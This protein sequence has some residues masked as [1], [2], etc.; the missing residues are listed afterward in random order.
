MNITGGHVGRTPSTLQ[1]VSA[2]IYDR[3]NGGMEK[4]VFGERRHRLLEAA[5]GSVLDVGAGTGANLPYYRMEEISRL[6][7]L[8]VGPGMLYRARRKAAEVGIEVEFQE[9]SAEQLPFDDDSFDTVVFTLSLC[10]IPDPVRALHEAR[11]VLKPGGTLL[12]LEHVKANDPSLAKWQDRVNPVWKVIS[13]GCHLNRDT[14]RNVEVAGFVF[15]SVEV[16]LEARIP[17]PLVRPQLLAAARKP[18][19]A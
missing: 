15:E 5:Q 2:A 13:S 9:A 8:D 4:K 17:F 14:R 7:L 3:I 19:D 6:V 16:G 11:R 18:A 12:V 1:R 10:T